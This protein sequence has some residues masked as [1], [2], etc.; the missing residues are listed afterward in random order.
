[1]QITSWRMISL[2]EFVNHVEINGLPYYLIG[3]ANIQEPW[4]NADYG[5]ELRLPTGELAGYIDL[6]NSN[7]KFIPG[8]FFWNDKIINR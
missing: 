2:P 4:R 5:I 8:V 3:T 7:L 6:L 1:M